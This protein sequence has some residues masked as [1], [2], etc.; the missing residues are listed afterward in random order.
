MLRSKVSA[1]VGM[2]ISVLLFL[3]LD[4]WLANQAH[5]ARDASDYRTYALWISLIGL[6]FCA[7][8]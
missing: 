4:R 2:V 1:L 7:L 6:A 3:G 5:I 8:V